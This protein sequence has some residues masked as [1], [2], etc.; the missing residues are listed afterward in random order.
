[1]ERADGWAQGHDRRANRPCETGLADRPAGILA[2]GKL[3]V[4]SR[5]KRSPDGRGRQLAAARLSVTNSIDGM[6]K[7][8]SG[9]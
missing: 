9:R 2:L 8:W 1:M 5:V 4:V 6:E 3:P 7:K